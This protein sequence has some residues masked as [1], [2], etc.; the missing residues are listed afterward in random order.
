MQRVGKVVLNLFRPHVQA[1]G[2]VDSMKTIDGMKVPVSFTSLLVIQPRR[3][4]RRS[5]IAGSEILSRVLMRLYMV[6][7]SRSV[8][9]PSYTRKALIGMILRMIPSWGMFAFQ[10]RGNDWVC[11]SLRSK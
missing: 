10:K 3:K 6:M 7:A 1:V 5:L 9:K 2:A 4:V 8:L 11:M